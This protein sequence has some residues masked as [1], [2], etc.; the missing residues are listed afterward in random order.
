MRARIRA[1]AFLVAPGAY[2]RPCTPCASMPEVPRRGQVTRRCVTVRAMTARTLAFVLASCCVSVA[3]AQ[4]PAPPKLEPGRWR[5]WV[6]YPEWEV[7]FELDVEARAGGAPVVSVRNGPERIPILRVEWRGE[8]LVLGLDHYT[9]EVVARP[10]ADG[11]SLE[12]VYRRGTGQEVRQHPFHARHGEPRFHPLAPD[13]APGDASSDPAPLVGR[14]SLT[15]EGK[16]RDWVA[17]FQVLED[18]SILG[19][20]ARETGDLRWLV[21]TF[22]R[23]VLRLSTWDGA[24]AVLYVGRLLPDGTLEGERWFGG[25]RTTWTA[26][27]DAAA[28]L[29][30]P[31]TMVQWNPK[32]EPL[33]LWF[34][35]VLGAGAEVKLGNLLTGKANVIYVLGTWCPN[36]TDQTETMV[37]LHARYADRGVGIVGLSYERTRDPVRAR[38]LLQEYV[39]RHGVSYPILF[40]GQ[41]HDRCLTGIDR[42]RSFPTTIF[43][44]SKGKVRGTFTGFRG[45]A[46]HEHA[47]MLARFEALIEEMLAE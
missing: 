22:E 2:A 46:S 20:T 30:D 21:G 43:V 7:P 36:C 40:G 38:T 44:D 13:A 5:A 12:G 35:D 6:S 9:G 27:K 17:T 47:E 16:E 42:L 19:N 39:R 1:E 3:S 29:P 33:R 32:V 14:W 8:D 25:G 18:G 15:N 34:R 4:E 11:R 31:W 45:P 10:G 23:G 41:A 24:H 37:E 28:A 26:R